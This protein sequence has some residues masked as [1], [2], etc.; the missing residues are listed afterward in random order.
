MLQCVTVYVCERESS[1]LEMRW[2]QTLW[3]MKVLLHLCC[4]VLQCDASPSV[5]QCVEF[6]CCSRFEFFGVAVR[7][8]VLQCVAVHCSALQRNVVCVCT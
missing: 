3:R 7:C 4:S 1:R 2:I 8:S 6:K 5:L